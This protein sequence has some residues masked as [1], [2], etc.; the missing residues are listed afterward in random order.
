[1]KLFQYNF[2]LLAVLV[3]HISCSKD[4]E[5]IPVIKGTN[6]EGEELMLSD[7]ASSIKEI[8]LETG[9]EI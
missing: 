6:V 5:G 9:D 4:P 3:F 7:I 8:P 2:L 1:M